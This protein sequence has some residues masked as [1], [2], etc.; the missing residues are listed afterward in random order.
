MYQRIA[1]DGPSYYR[2]NADQNRV[3]RLIRHQQTYIK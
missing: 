3:H 2:K 1:F